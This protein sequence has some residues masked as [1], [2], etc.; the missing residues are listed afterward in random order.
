MTPD[1]DR[2][3]ARVNRSATAMGLKPTVSEGLWAELVADGL[4]RFPRDAELYI[5]P[6]YWAEEGFAG[7][8]RFDPESTNHALCLYV[9]PMPLPTGVRATLSPYRRPTAD[10]AP[11]EAKAG[12]LYPNGARAL[13]EAYGRGFGNC[14]LRDA[15]GNVAEFAN[16]NAFLAKDGVV[17]TPVANGS[18]LAGITRA[19][20]IALLRGAGVTVVEET[21]SYAD[22]QAAD[23]VFTAG[24]FAKLA[25]VTALDERRFEPGPMFRRARQLYWD[26]AHA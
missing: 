19:R 2:H 16:A 13:T 26:F 14:M 11:V 21:L 17:R 10:C 12:C 15:L 3:L 5:R 7:G 18:F 24:N 6:M 23:E 25:P 22:F 9:A 20:V 8:V 4:S 1:L